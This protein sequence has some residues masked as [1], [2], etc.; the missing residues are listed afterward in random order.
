[1]KEEAGGGDEG[2]ESSV[3]DRDECLR[4]LPSSLSEPS[5]AN[6]NLK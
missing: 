1:M 2:V 6:K 4:F 5:L 3:N